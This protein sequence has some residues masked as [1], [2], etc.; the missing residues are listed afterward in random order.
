MMHLEESETCRSVTAG[1]STEPQISLHGIW[2]ESLLIEI[3]TI[4][5]LKP[6]ESLSSVAQNVN[7][8]LT[9]N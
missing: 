5:R 8:F 2:V 7:P 6:L 1:R 4:I 9:K 3:T